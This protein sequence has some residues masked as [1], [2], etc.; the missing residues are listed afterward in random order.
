MG[1]NYEQYESVLSKNTN[2]FSNATGDTADLQ[3]KVARLEGELTRFN[4]RWTQYSAAY[5]SCR[6]EKKDK[7][8]EACLKA[9]KPDVDSAN[10]S[11]I[12]VSRELVEAKNALATEIKRAYDAE[13]IRLA[14]AEREI[15]RA[16]DAEQIRLADAERE[17]IR[18]AGIEQTRLEDAERERIRLAGIEQKRLEDAAKKVIDDA[19]IADDKIK[20]DAAIELAKKT[21]QDLADAQKKALDIK[22]EIDLKLVDKG[23]VPEAELKKAELA[24]Q[25]VVEAAKINATAQAKVTELTGVSTS[26][27]K[28]YLMI[29]GFLVLAIGA[30][31]FFRK[32][33]E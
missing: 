14:D 29:G 16:Y 8:R 10:S 23:V 2:D 9:K 11:S 6:S 18:L 26:K 32:K 15:K 20:T 17:R 5:E 27:T 12:R 28:N 3:A 24:G 1:F 19:K 33:T 30:F 21:A 13:Q 25:A 31:L 4:D 22:K 7:D